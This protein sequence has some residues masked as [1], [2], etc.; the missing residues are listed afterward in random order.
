MFKAEVGFSPKEYHLSIQMDKAYKYLE[1]DGMS[2]AQAAE[3][4]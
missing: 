2:V 4:L 1:G 3:Q